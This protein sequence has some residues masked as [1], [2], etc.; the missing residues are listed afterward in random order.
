[1]GYMVMIYF[2]WKS[3]R[4]FYK[5]KISYSGSLVNTWKQGSWNRVGRRV[6]RDFKRP[7]KPPVRP[8]K[9]QR[10]SRSA[11]FYPS[12]SSKRRRFCPSNSID[13]ESS[14]ATDRPVLERDCSVD[15]S[16]DCDNSNDDTVVE[17]LEEIE[18][19]FSTF[20][21]RMEDLDDDTYV[22]ENDEE[23]TRNDQF[24]PVTKETY[25][26]CWPGDW[27]PLDCPGVRVIALN[28]TT[29]PYLWRPVWI[30]KRI[31]SSLAERARE[32]MKM[33]IEIGVGS[34]HPIVW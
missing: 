8:P 3:L 18:Y 1:M 5:E 25:S 26:K 21:M 28:Y 7:P 23:T 29:D 32:M 27:L 19:N 4:V 31:R 13:G 12:H 9:R 22:P 17:Y 20:R 6:K 24:T 15:F 30:K 2:Y 16:Y 33:L 34:G 10:H 11:L 14:N